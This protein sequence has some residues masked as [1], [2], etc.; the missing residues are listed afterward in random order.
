MERLLFC[1]DLHGY[2]DQFRQVLTHAQSEA[3]H[4]WGFARTQGPDAGRSH[5]HGLIR[6]HQ[7]DFK[8]LKW[9]I[10]TRSPRAIPLLVIVR[11]VMNPVFL[12]WLR[13]A[14]HPG[15]ISSPPARFSAVRCPGRQESCPPPYDSLPA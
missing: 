14:M 12:G 9:N 13:S 2:L 8:T 1:A 3:D 5:A 4:R 10:V 15:I 7:L 11:Q 6:H